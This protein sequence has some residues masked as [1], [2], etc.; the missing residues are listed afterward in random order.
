MASL[1]LLVFRAFPTPDLW[2]CDQQYR[3]ETGCLEQHPA[4]PH[5]AGDL[6]SRPYPLDPWKFRVI[7]SGEIFLIY[8]PP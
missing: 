5:V 7:S 2:A 6:W 4:K 1:C 8:I 3:G